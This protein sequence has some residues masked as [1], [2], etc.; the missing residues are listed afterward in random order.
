M[1]FERLAIKILIV[2]NKGVRLLVSLCR[3]LQEMA[4]DQPFMLHQRSVAKLF[5]RSD[6]HWLKVCKTVCLLKVADPCRQGRA[7]R[8]FYLE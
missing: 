6:H 3:E 1:D 4:G 8:Y 2:G 7:M 5:G